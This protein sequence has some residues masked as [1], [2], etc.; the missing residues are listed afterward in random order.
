MSRSSK[1]GVASY[2]EGGQKLH[3]WVILHE[4]LHRLKE[5]DI[6]YVTCNM[7]HSPI[8]IVTKLSTETKNKVQGGRDARR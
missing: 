4:K 1:D 5:I 7:L 3:A 2:V 6:I 8:E